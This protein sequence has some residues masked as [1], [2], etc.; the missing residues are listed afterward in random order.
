VQIRVN[1]TVIIA[2]YDRPDELARLL[3]SL[4]AQLRSGDELI[5]AENGTPQPVKVP[6]NA[7]PLKHLHELRGGKC[8]SQNR[9]IAE[10]RGEVVVLVD[11]DLTVE[12]RYLDAVER[13]FSEH[14][15][16]AAM[17]GRILP[18]EDPEAKVGTNWMYLDLPIFDRGDHVVEVPGVLGANMAFRR[19]ALDAVGLFDERLG[20]GAA[21]H[22]EETEMSQR[23]RRK[24]LRIGYAPDAVVYHEVDPRRADRDRFIRISRE[25]GRCRMLH[26]A[27]SAFEVIT[28]NA[29][30]WTRL[31]IA[32]SLR[33]SLP[34]I[35]RE[36][37][38]LAVAQG[39]FDGLGFQPK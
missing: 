30:A 27:H 12:A 39:M 28:K 16:F 33:A 1:L 11:D 13:F 32:R 31:T 26:E 15:Q 29:I 7:P 22:E 17:A 2:T 18:A 24:G 8:R 36:E 3:A 20:P 35:A 4:A 5:I 37:R 10:S 25:R 9:A 14:P 34:R 19:S 21:G 38:R 23:L 6:P